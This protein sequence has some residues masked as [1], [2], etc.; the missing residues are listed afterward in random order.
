MACPGRDFTCPLLLFLGRTY[1]GAGIYLI[2]SRREIFVL[3]RIPVLYPTRLAHPLV[4]G[5]PSRE[6]AAC[7]CIGRAHPLFRRS[8]R[9]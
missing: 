3:V 9:P 6:K 2:G 4:H 8:R 5:S 1:H 7:Y